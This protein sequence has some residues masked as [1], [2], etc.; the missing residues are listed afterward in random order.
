MIEAHDICVVVDG[1]KRLLDR[2][3]LQVPAAHLTALVGPNGAGKSTLLSVITGDLEPTSGTLTMQG[4]EVESVPIRE[5]A[6]LRAV[7]P[8]DHSV[9]FGF[10]V[11][12]VVTMGRAPHDTIARDDD[13]I[14]HRTMSQTEITPFADRNI[15]TLSGG[16]QART[17]FARVLTQQTPILC[18]DEPTAALDLRYQELVLSLARQLREE[19][20][21]VIVVLHDLNL[22]AAYADT[23]V[24]LANGRIAAQGTPREVLQA[25]LIERVYR[26]RVLVLEHPVRGHPLI[27]TTD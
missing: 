1:G 25:T 27:V 20:A 21:C 17:A 7:L 10:S 11:R 26:Q 18:L 23:I 5:L 9:R 22:A 19:G 2:V 4:R 3:S 6:R 24:M 8:Q 14:V 12:E 15:L 16:E 13:Q